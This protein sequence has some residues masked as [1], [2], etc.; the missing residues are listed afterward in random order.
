MSSGP[1]R[2]NWAREELVSNTPPPKATE[3]ETAEP[4]CGAKYIMTCHPSNTNAVSVTATMSL[5]LN[6]ATTRCGCE[7]PSTESNAARARAQVAESVTKT[8][9]EGCT[10]AG[11]PSESRMSAYMG[12]VS[13]LIVRSRSKELVSSADML[14]HPSVTIAPVDALSAPR[15]GM[16]TERHTITT[17]G[18]CIRVP[19]EDVRLAGFPRTAWEADLSRL[20]MTTDLMKSEL[21]DVVS[22]P[23][24]RMSCMRPSTCP[25]RARRHTRRGDRPSRAV[26]PP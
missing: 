25:P 4:H 14:L 24:R 9:S 17:A 3:T 18:V 15:A 10:D 19:V 11:S 16:A 7:T 8:T 20:R 23:R 2:S 22:A 26:Q 5:T 13:V 6:T 21:V 1:W 12:C